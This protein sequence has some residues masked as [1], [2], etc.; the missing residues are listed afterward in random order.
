MRDEL[1]IMIIWHPRVPTRNLIQFEQEVRTRMTTD[2]VSHDAYPYLYVKPYPEPDQLRDWLQMQFPE[3]D[4]YMIWKG[5][6]L[7]KHQADVLITSITWD[8]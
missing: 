3:P 2:G 5:W 8:K 1:G 6:I 7:F 4:L